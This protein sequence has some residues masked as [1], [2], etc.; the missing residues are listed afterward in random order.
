MKCTLKENNILQSEFRHLRNQASEF[1]ING[2][3]QNIRKPY[4]DNVTPRDKVQS[5]QMYRNAIVEVF[6]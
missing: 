6:T 4:T 2:K 1:H 3:T 5:D